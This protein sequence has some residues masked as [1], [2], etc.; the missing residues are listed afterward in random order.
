MVSRD[1]YATVSQN[2]TIYEAILALEK[3]I[4]LYQESPHFHRA[5]LAVNDENRVVG[6]VTLWVILRSLEPKYDEVGDPSAMSRFGFT[7]SFIES[8]MES[9]G[10]WKESLDTM[11]GHAAGIR[12]KDIM[13]RPSE[14]EYVS[15]EAP[16]SQGIHQLIMGHHRSLLVTD[17]QRVVGVL[18]LVD[19]FWEVCRRIKAAKE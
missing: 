1:D 10:L 19:V 6:K 18:R 14:G 11:C 17:G 3:A 13:Y 4:E 5:V 2:A 12:V 8:M 9:Q 7:A 15:P 16:L